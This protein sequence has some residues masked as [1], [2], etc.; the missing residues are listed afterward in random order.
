MKRVAIA[1]LALL[2]LASAARAQT[3]EIVTFEESYAV[4]LNGDTAVK[5]QFKLFGAERYTTI[6][7]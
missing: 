6:K 4:S 2:V 3:P 7:K 1:I 5:I